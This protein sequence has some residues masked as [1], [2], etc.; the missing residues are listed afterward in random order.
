MIA[1]YIQDPAHTSRGEHS[2]ALCW[3]APER[4]PSART[5]CSRKV[6]N[7][8]GGG[9]GGKALEGRS[10]MSSISAEWNST[11]SRTCR[12]VRYPFSG[13]TPDRS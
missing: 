13:E 7:G 11:L 1:W 10:S 4:S 8:G 6:Q 9:G 3:R 12:Q 5:M 2:H